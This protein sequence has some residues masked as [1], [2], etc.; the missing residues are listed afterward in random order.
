MFLTLL[1]G[2]TR[3]KDRCAVRYAVDTQ[4]HIRALLTE[5]RGGLVLA[6]TNFDEIIFADK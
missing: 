2:A 5:P 6:F 4:S 1:P 3:P